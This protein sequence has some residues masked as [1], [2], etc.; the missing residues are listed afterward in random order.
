MGSNL[1]Y[2]KSWINYQENSS[3]KVKVKKQKFLWS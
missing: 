1:N 3:T 2:N